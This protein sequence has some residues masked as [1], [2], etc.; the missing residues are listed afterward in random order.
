MSASISTVVTFDDGTTL[1]LSECAWVRFLP[2]GCA[3]GV[4]LA[5]HSPTEADTWLGFTHHETA[6]EVAHDKALGYRLE[7]HPRGRGLDL[8]KAGDDC[9]HPD[10]GLPSEPALP[11]GYVWAVKKL[12]GVASRVRHAVLLGPDD[13]HPHWSTKGYRSK[14]T[15][16]CRDVSNR[17]HI[18]WYFAEDGDKSEW[19]CHPQR[20]LD[21]ALPCKNCTKKLVAP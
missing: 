4:A 6:K 19:W 8:L 18:G 20:A 16:L 7:L 5:E 9:T 21:A 1:P 12:T 13:A 14:A 3:C 10:R 15:M 17:R 11:E 2:C